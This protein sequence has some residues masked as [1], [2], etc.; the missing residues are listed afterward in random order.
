MKSNNNEGVSPRRKFLKTIGAGTAALGIAA[1]MAPIQKIQASPVYE[2]DDNDPSP[3]DWFKQLKGKHRMVFDVTE[4]HEVFPFA[5]PKVYTLTNI[6]TG[7]SEKDVNSVVVLRHHAIGYAFPDAMWTKYN[8]G[9]VFNITDP[10]TNKPSLRNPFWQ[11]KPGDFAFPGL[12]NVAIGIN[13]L[14]A[15]GVLFCACNMAITVYSAVLAEKMKLN[16]ED[17]KKEWQAN[18]LPGIPA[19]PSGVWAV[20]RAQENGCGYCFVR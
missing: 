6:A 3:D 4:A 8:F 5:W 20:G 18:L 16:A 13:E 12:G 9:E 17:V 1:V 7:S 15:T 11:P 19:M 14:Q 10:K 2:S